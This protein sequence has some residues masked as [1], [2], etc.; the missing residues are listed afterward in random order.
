MI[1]ELKFLEKDKN[2]AYA[3]LNNRS[4]NIIQN[5]KNFK[6]LYVI[7]SHIDYKDALQYMF[8]YAINEIPKDELLVVIG[9]CKEN[10]EV[11]VHNVN[12]ALVKDNKYDFH[13]FKYI[14]NNFKKYNNFDYIFY[15][16]DTCCPFKGFYDL[17]YNFTPGCSTHR[18]WS[19]CNSNLGLYSFKWLKSLQPTITNKIDNIINGQTGQALEDKLLDPKCNSYGYLESLFEHGF[20]DKLLQITPNQATKYCG[21]SDIY[22]NDTFRRTEYHRQINLA[23]FKSNS[24]LGGYNGKQ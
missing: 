11:K 20:G 21:F 17:S 15:M 1:D 24:Y 8:P 3:R 4:N 5:K 12:F 6:I 22:N 23:K 7:N 13:A 2:I 10:K 18:V 14:I 19:N 9:G 16:H